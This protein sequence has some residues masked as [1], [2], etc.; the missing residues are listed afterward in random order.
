[1]ADPGL[2]WLQL[3]PSF[4]LAMYTK[5][6]FYAHGTLKRPLPAKLILTAH[7]QNAIKQMGVASAFDTTTPSPPM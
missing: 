3:I 1:M 5:S 7:Q 6:V 2:H 4:G